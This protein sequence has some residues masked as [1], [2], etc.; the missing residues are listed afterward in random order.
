M[1][2]P[3]F[4]QLCVAA[5]TL[6]GPLTDR[7]ATS[8]WTIGQTVQ[9][10][11]GPVA[12]HAARNQSG[13][14]EYLGIPFAQPPIGDLR[15]A[16]PVKYTGDATL[17][18]TSF[19]FSCPIQV[20]NSTSVPNLALAN[21]TA[22]G[23]AYLVRT[24]PRSRF[25]EDCL[26]LN[27]WTKPQTG[28]AKKAVLVWIYGGGF[29]SGSSSIALYDGA[30]L[31]DQEDVI[32]VSF[33]YRLSIF[34]FSGNPGGPGNVAFLDQRL[35]IEWVRDN[36][37]NFGGDASRI[38]IFGQSAGAAS[39]DFY[40][41]AW[42]SDPIAAG[43]IS[44]SGTVFSWSLPYSKAVA[45]KAW[46][47][48]VSNAG[49]GDAS[50]DNATVLSCMQSK[51][52]TDIFNALPAVTGIGMVLG[53]FGPSVD[54]TVVFANY[55][56]RTPAAL[57]LLIG[58]NDYEAGLF[59][60]QFALDNIT[61]S[62]ADWDAFNLQAF[63][64]P[65]GIRAN[66]SIAENIPTFRY[67]YMGEF[68]NTRISAGSGA[69]HAAELLLLFNTAN[70]NPPSTAEQVSIG[71][72]M[73]G[74]WATFAKDPAKGLTNYGWPAYGTGDSLVRL[75]YNNL[76]GTNAVNPS[77]Y[78]AECVNFNVSSPDYQ[79]L[80]G[81]SGAGTPTTPTVNPGS[82]GS[83][84]SSP[85]PTASRSAGTTK[86]ASLFRAE[87]RNGVG[88]GLEEKLCLMATSNG[89][90]GGR[91]GRVP[92]T[93]GSMTIL[94]G[95]EDTVT[96]NPPGILRDPTVTA[97]KLNTDIPDILPHER[98]FPIQIGSEL[99]RLSGASIS[100]DGMCPF[101]CQLKT[102]EESGEESTGVRT[103]YIDR[104]PVTFR[105]ISL[106][107]QGYHV[108]PKNGSHYVKLFADAQFY[109][110]PRLISQLYEE[111]IFISIGHRD[112]QIP[113]EIFQDPGNSPNFFS[114]GYG[115]FF[116]TPTEVFP[117]LNRDGL[118][119]PPSILPPA[120]PNRSAEIFSEIIHLLRGYPL[121]IRNE[122]HRAELLRDC[123]YFHLKGLEQKLIRHSISY[124]LARRKSEIT[125]R[126]E[127]VR[128]SGISVV[129][130]AGQSPPPTTPA[131]DLLPNARPGLIG[132]VNYARPFV[133]PKAYELV[134]EIGDECTKLHFNSHPASNTTTMRAE[135]FG[136]G[137]T[138]ISRLF[139]VIATK[140]NLP[141][142]QPLGLLMKNGGATSQPAS[143][144]N[145]PLSHEG[146][147]VR[148]VMGDDAWVCLDGKEWKG[149]GEEDGSIA[150]LS[151]EDEHPR[152]QKRRRTDGG[153]EEHQRWIVKTG[154]WRL[155]VQQNHGLGGKEECVLVAV[156]L[157]AVSGELGRNAQRGFLGS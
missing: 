120:V 77:V 25:D 137:K 74:A 85:T 8:N 96:P 4:L 152:P 19:G 51:S 106:H 118:L 136:D 21:V 62:D 124:N 131:T 144:G 52:T 91:E 130:D 12:G 95:R 33:N 107:L 110:L 103:L 104:D 57:P 105:D 10:S 63:T 20:T 23:I 42:K 97:R 47:D 115:V 89:G 128:Q 94:T 116:S 141:N 66:A 37:E 139:E 40:S 111:S 65:A 78:D 84:T 70:T 82:G 132:Y 35:A 64:C 73:R 125:L 112:F 150:S 53:S 58:S 11:S 48:T 59:R 92:G 135:F 69:Y 148:C 68:A 13:V 119:R 17:N 156:K 154:Q 49:C 32:V 22:A 81:S 98:V 90:T 39:V 109:S 34:G 153:L 5:L 56:S 2:S 46:F 61:F 114:L 18:G 121:H 24:Q 151:M 31:A 93:T 138:R 147:L 54:D 155:K 7:Q 117:G 14:S 76:T 38:T 41:Y 16:A 127:D 149:R 134:L 44:E 83:P 9:T 146:D 79:G 71:D 36:I 108:A 99:F 28:E 29:N 72:Y 133:D 50:S 129:T 157:D 87:R 86:S 101:A 126:L 122:N 1:K 15:F 27:V 6:A 3:V 67:R 140:L 142:S 100:S 123:K 43:F 75:G 102:A 143:P 88:S 113:K 145:T 30:N 55:T 45:S 80:A 60:T 26:T